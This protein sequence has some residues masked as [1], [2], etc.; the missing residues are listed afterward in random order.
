MWLPSSLNGQTAIRRPAWGTCNVT[1]SS[2]SKRSERA[3]SKLTGG[4]PLP[5][6]IHGRVPLSFEE[7][8]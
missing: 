2:R 8:I 1:Y 3:Q 7:A 5:S 6:A 4:F